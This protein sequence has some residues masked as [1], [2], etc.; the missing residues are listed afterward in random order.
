MLKDGVNVGAVSADDSIEVWLAPQPEESPAQRKT[1]SS[2]F[3]ARDAFGGN[4]STMHNWGTWNAA[5]TVKN[6]VREDGFWHS[7][8]AL[9]WRELG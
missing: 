4:A 9:P 8:M 2:I 7:E 6:S 3:N 1:F 5:W